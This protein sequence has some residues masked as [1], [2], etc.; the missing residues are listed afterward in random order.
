MTVSAEDLDQLLETVDRA[1]LA[2]KTASACAVLRALVHHYPD[3]PR[4]WQRLADIGE[5]PTERE[6]AQRQLRWLQP[7]RT[8]IP[9]IALIGGGTLLLLLLIWSLIALIAPATTAEREQSASTSEQQPP[10]QSAPTPV[11]VAPPD[12]AAVPAS[13]NSAELPRPASPTPS[14]TQIPPTPE[15]LTLGTVLEYDSWQITLLDMRYVQQIDRTLVF[16]TSTDVSTNTLSTS[17]TNTSP[18]TLVVL[19]I[20]NNHNR[21]R[22]LPANLFHLV[23]PEGQHYRPLSN[24]SSDYLARVG[25]GQY[26]DLA[27][28]DPIPARSGLVSVPLLFDTAPITDNLMLTLDIDTA[29]GWP[30]TPINR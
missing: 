24:A 4:I 30:L 22:L 17:P 8:R 18:L 19:A 14:P 29:Q 9:P 5:T 6:A 20:S 2:G 1:V 7:R 28:E 26:G 12:P 23:T 3:D 13:D 11:A 25:R 15:P 16:N 21:P 27:L 10:A